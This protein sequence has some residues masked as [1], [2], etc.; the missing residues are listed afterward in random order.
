MRAHRP[1]Q[2]LIFPDP[3]HWIERLY[4]ALVGVLLMAM[5]LVWSQSMPLPLMADDV[6]SLVQACRLT[7]IESGTLYH[8]AYCGIV[9]LTKDYLLAFSVKQLAMLI[10][11][12]LLCYRL[13]RAY[14]IRP[15]LAITLTLWL[16][17]AQLRIHGTAYAALLLVLLGALFMRYRQPF[18]WL[19]LIFT[20][21]IA[22]FI[23]SEF[24]IGLYAT[25]LVAL[26]AARRV[27]WRQRQHRVFWQRIAVLAI[28]CALL[29]TGLFVASR[30]YSAQ[31]PGYI[32]LEWRAFGQHYA[33]NY[34]E[35]NHIAGEPGIEWEQIVQLSFP[36]SR[37]FFQAMIE[38]PGAVLW[39]IGYNLRYYLGP[40]L[41]G[42]LIP[43]ERSWLSAVAALLILFTM[44]VFFSRRSISQ[45]THLAPLLVFGTIP[46][47]GLLMIQPT[48]EYL[49][50]LVPLLLLLIGL[51][52]EDWIISK[53]WPS[54]ILIMLLL[55]AII[56]MASIRIEAEIRVLGSSQVPLR[57]ALLSMRA[58]AQRKP[59]QPVRVMA[60]WYADRICGLMQPQACVARNLLP[61]DTPVAPQQSAASLFGGGQTDWL[62][63]GPD[64][65]RLGS[66]QS[67]PVLREWS[68]ELPTHGCQLAFESR[69]CFFVYDCR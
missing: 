48:T 9:A 40:A 39:Q 11:I 32:S 60:S 19:L 53:N 35:A 20:L 12:A 63:V 31:V 3:P 7:S 27:S 57:V 28:A 56:A 61:T 65:Q 21:F 42:L 24:L 6:I 55:C 13:L 8:L 47:F 43:A 2:A 58:E 17:T 69:E 54:N 51:E 59:T 41:A 67:D 16:M 45:R 5:L 26:I 34:A 66:I 23:R 38:N 50:P 37:S 68:L 14:T 22:F 33:L 44:L 1:Q 30:L 36:K 29:C 62:I 46:I 49:L 18:A 64:W 4:T 10:M 25:A 15:A 52:L